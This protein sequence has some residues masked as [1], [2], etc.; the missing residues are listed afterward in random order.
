[1][2]RRLLLAALALACLTGGAATSTPAAAQQ[3]YRFAIVPKAMNN[4]FFD[5]AR[6]GCRARAAELGNVECVY[7]G[8]VEHEPATQTQ[9][10]QDLITQRVDGLAISVSD[11]AASRRV[12]QRAVEAGIPVITFDADAPQSQRQAYIG[13]DNLEFGRALGRQLVALRPRPGSYAM[14][15]GG[16]AALNLNDRVKGVREVLQAAGWTEVPGSPTFCNDDQA[17]AVQQMADLLTA[18]PRLDAIVPV[19]GWPMFVPQAFRSFV[20]NNRARLEEGALTLVVADTLRVQLELLRD[21]YASALVGQRPYE[22]G[23]RAMDALLA[24]KK[25]EKVPEITHVGVDLVTRDKAAA[26][27]R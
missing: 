4:P 7:L 22:M 12:I 25:G 26:M 10:I 3:R 18:N 19:G 11:A 6:D 17:L 21:G 16:P 23:Q 8:P 27:L 13:T 9:I 20:D 24:L 15:S 2:T 14:V 1:M 5:L